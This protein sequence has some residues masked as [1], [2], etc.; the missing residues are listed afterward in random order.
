MRDGRAIPFAVDAFRKRSLLLGLDEIGEILADDLKDIET[1]EEA[2][3]RER[4][5]LYLTREQL[6]HFSDLEN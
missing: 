4:P 3:R 1:F 2:Q 6:S 5:W